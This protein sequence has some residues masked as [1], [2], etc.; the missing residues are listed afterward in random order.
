VPD[1]LSGFFSDGAS[2]TP[3]RVELAEGPENAV[4]AR[5]A[6]RPQD[7]D[8]MAHVNNA[9]DVDYLEEA[10]LSGG[11]GAALERLPR[12]YRLEYILSAERGA[13]L[14]ASSWADEGGWAMRLRDG[15]GNELLRARLE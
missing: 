1:E 12:R 11:E 3:G 15:A 9:T 10:L 5:L 14:L 8:P 7:L 13:D 6:V 2:F 4:S